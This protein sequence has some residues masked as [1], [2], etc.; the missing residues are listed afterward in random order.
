MSMTP[1]NA[2][3]TDRRPA[4][5]PV[6]VVGG[7]AAGMMA[8]GFAASRGR[9]VLLLERGARLGRKLSITGKGRC[10]LTNRCEA[11]EV[12]QNVP[13]N[14]RFLYSAVTAFPPEAVMAFFEG[15]G[16]PLKTERG[17]RVFPAS[18]R[19]ASVVEA[20]RAF[21]R[22]SGARV[23]TGRAVS[24]L[25]KDG[26][27]RG[28]KTE[29]G[30]TFPA[31][32]VILC[33][34]GRSY[35]LTGSTGDGY[36]LARQAGHTIIPP[37]GSL[38]PLVED[39]DECARMAGLSLRNTALR[40]RDGRGKVI[41]ED[42]G[43]LLFTHFGL[44]GPTALS[45]SA[46][47]EPGRRY[48]VELD[49]KPALDEKKLD[50]RILRDFA[51]APNRTFEHALP[52]LL[53]RSMIPVVAARAGVP[54]DTRVNAV[55]KER[56]RALRDTLKRFCVPIAGARPVEEAIV[57]AGGVKV[58]E[59]DPGTMA[60]KRCR[61]LYFAGEL[62]DVDAYTGGFNLQIA[63]ATGRAAGLAAAGQKGEGI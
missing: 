21:L 44:S 28:V 62:L 7:G 34:G 23:E 2:L 20:L 30:E 46:H 33:T 39:G 12:L 53:P 47:M 41:Y 56:R 54:L 27:A 3:S 29:T 43:E 26:A 10:N 16:C 8:A 17:N 11:A 57:T 19:S 22:E 38:V 63:W 18:D 48:T 59:V 31:S 55:T 52:A 25:L 60:S 61:G 13:R 35:P 4:D 58:S 51:D 15:L 1:M 50:A 24:L 40:L 42:F 5:G 49:L 45:A 14:A 36:R 9:P 6:L 32:A 37:R